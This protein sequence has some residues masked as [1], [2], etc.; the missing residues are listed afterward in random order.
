MVETASTNGI[1]L[2]GDGGCECVDMVGVTV[3][4]NVGGGTMRVGM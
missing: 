4:R 3:V 1:G 2:L